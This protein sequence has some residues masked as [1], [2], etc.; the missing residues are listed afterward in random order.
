VDRA[1][2][3]GELPVTDAG[4]ALGKQQFRA[5]REQFLLQV[6]VPQQESHAFDEQPGVEPLCAKSL[7]PAAKASPIT[8]RSLAAV[9]IRIGRMR[10]PVILR[11]SRQASVPDIF[12]C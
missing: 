9:S 3:D 2:L 11:S 8:G 10:F 5:A 12:A 6:P 1:A 7:A 4:D